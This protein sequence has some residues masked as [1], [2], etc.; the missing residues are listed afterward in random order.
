MLPYFNIILLE[1]RLDKK[2]SQLM[3]CPLCFITKKGYECKNR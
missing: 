2:L 1:M 3:D